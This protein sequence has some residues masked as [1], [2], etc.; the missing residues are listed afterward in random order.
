[1]PAVAIARDCRSFEVFNASARADSAVVSDWPTSGAS[2]VAPVKL[3]AKSGCVDVFAKACSKAVS[4]FGA[5]RMLFIN[6]VN[7]VSEFGAANGE[8]M[9]PVVV[10]RVTG[11]I[12]GAVSDGES[13][14]FQNRV[15]SIFSAEAQ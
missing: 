14:Q 9:D 7:V 2:C 8:E 13:C 3:A 1:M 4:A 12:G 11:L 10:G 5:L 6:G 15:R